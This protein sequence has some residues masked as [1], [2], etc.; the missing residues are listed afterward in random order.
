MN[1]SA[2]L[3]IALTV[4]GLAFQARASTY[5]ASV[6]YAKTPLAAGV[7]YTPE[8]S[9]VLLFKIIDVIIGCGIM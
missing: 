1:K 8:V 7:N 6:V 9:F 2:V 5:I 3:V 4:L